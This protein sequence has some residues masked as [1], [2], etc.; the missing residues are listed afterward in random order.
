MSERECNLKSKQCECLQKTPF[1]L[2]RL[3]SFIT[4]LTPTLQRAVC[5]WLVNRRW[6]KRR[7]TFVLGRRFS[8]A[9]RGDNFSEV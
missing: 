8:F 6:N 5:V 9:P 2:H 3:P 4:P 1:T 7:A